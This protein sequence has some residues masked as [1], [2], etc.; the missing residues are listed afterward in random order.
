MY[1][2]KWDQ[3]E[4]IT[5]SSLNTLIVQNIYNNKNIFCSWINDIHR[6]IQLDVLQKIYI[7]TMKQE[8]WNNL[9]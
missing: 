9:P 6:I 4:M 1:N 5:V 2:V 7:Q 8:L 3:L